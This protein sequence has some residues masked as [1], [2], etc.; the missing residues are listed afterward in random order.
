MDVQPSQYGQHHD[1]WPEAAEFR[2]K[3]WMISTGHSAAAQ[4]KGAN[5]QSWGRT[6]MISQ[7]SDITAAF[8]L[9]AGS[10]FIVTIVIFM[11]LQFPHPGPP[12]CQQRVKPAVLRAP[13]AP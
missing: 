10:S 7:I 5:R 1:R 12:L 3:T 13:Y 9:A 8:H 11:G 2:Y 4:A 6:A